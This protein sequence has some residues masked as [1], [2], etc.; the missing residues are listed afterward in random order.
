MGWITNRRIPIC[1]ILLFGSLFVAERFTNNAHLI[2][3]L[4]IMQ[5]SLSAAVFS[6]Y[7]ADGVPLL[8]KAHAS[9]T[10]YAALGI[11]CKAISLFGFGVWMTLWRLAG[12]P[13]W[14]LDSIVQMVMIAIGTAGALLLL[15]A[16]RI[17]SRIPAPWV[18]R[19]AIGVGVGFAIFGFVLVNQPKTDGFVK[20]MEPW[21]RPRDTDMEYPTAFPPS[22]YR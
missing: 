11:S 8:F 13:D 21:A 14:M 2:E 17:D 19:M 9:P 1:A 20:W 6:A 15:G 16:P 10:E 4:R 18:L 3:F 22:P 5:F 7:I 12:K